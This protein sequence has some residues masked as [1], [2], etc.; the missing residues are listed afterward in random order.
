MPRLLFLLLLLMAQPAS[1]ARLEIPLRVPLDTVR[2]AMKTALGASLYR[3][4]RCRY[5][6]LGEPTLRA[7]QGRLR[8]S[9]PGNGSLGAEIGGTCRRAVAWRG[10]V[11]FT[12]V[13]RIDEA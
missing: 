5:L 3:D 12:L 2:E 9:G 6:N 11:D 13:P 8:L 7:D 10:T 1:A 4:G